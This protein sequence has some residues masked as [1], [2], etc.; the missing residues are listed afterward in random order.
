[1]LSVV[2]WLT[3]K[4]WGHKESAVSVGDPGSI[5]GSGRSLEK[6]WQPT[7]VFLPGKSHGRRNLAGYSPWGSQS[8]TRL[9]DFTSSLHLLITHTLSSRHP[10]KCLPCVISFNPSKQV[11]TSWVRYSFMKPE[12]AQGNKVT[13]LSICTLIAEPTLNRCTP[14]NLKNKGLSAR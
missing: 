4:V 7:P 3:S 11:R 9:S 2:K 6:E 8:R 5:P 14:H 10:A 12:K 1:M 13:S